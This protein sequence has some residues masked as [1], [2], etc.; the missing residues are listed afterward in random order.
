M[1]DSMST[2]TKSFATGDLDT[3]RRELESTQDESAGT[4]ELLARISYMQGRYDTA[5]S[6]LHRVVRASRLNRLRRYRAHRHLSLAYFQ[7]NQYDM[8]ASLPLRD[9]L[10]RLMRSFAAEPYRTTW[11]GGQ[12]TAVPFLQKEDW[13]LP[14]VGLQTGGTDLIAKIDTGGDLLSVP[15]TVA[16]QLGIDPVATSIGWYAG[17][18]HARTGYGVLPEIELGDVTIEDVPIS[19]NNLDTPVVG[20]GLLRQF[21]P[22]VDYPGG[23]LVLERRRA[24]VK[25]GIPFLLAGVH[26]LVVFGSVNGKTMP[27]LVD[28]GLEVSNNGCFLAPDSTLE[29]TG[30]E[31]PATEK[32]SGM[33]GAGT[34]KLEIGEFNV[35]E[36]RL[37]TATMHDAIG[38]TGIFPKQLSRASTIGFPIGGLVSHNFLRA[39]K[40]TIDFDEM[41][42]ALQAE[43]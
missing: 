29:A 12:Q 2:P 17:G 22:T 11:N 15:W 35:D 8:A 1:V 26:L 9:S 13:E 5:I 3:A 16:K 21:L 20:T 38:L 42:M 31:V 7:T 39:Y 40:W 14:R 33:G 41:R 23:K 37:G 18:K 10:T 4:L 19:I 34:T 43:K 25:D 36:L 24:A 6:Q 30:I 32:V 27:L 28:S